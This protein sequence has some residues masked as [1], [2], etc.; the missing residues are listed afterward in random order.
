MYVLGGV[1][2]LGQP[3]PAHPVGDEVQRGALTVRFFAQ[4]TGQRR[5]KRL[6]PE[7]PTRR[8]TASQGRETALVIGIGATER[9]PRHPGE[10]CRVSRS[11]E[12][13]D[14]RVEAQVSHGEPDAEQGGPTADHR[15]PARGVRAE[16]PSGGVGVQLDTLVL[17]LGDE[18]PR[19]GVVGR[20]SRDGR[21]NH[22]GGRMAPVRRND[23]HEQ[24][25]RRAGIPVHQEC[26]E[27]RWSL[28][29]GGCGV[30]GS[31]LR[32]RRRSSR[33]ARPSTAAVSTHVTP[34]AS[35]SSTTNRSQNSGVRLVPTV[36]A[37]PGRRRSPCF[38][39]TPLRNRALGP[40]WVVQE[41]GRALY[42][43]SH[44]PEGRQA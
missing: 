26:T 1:Q 40:K 42:T 19:L 25:S 7:W 21:P 44:G 22:V 9:A 37:L 17:S 4:D 32:V 38:Q 8:V 33:T 31:V 15:L 36:L 5:G 12:P 23:G 16:Q 28:R 43:R 24:A 6:S 35:T 11:R 14:D 2:Q 13:F 39:P 27:T 10:E 20:R 3:A 29:C 18:P 41:S 34:A 30:Q